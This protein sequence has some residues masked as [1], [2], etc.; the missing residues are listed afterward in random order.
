MGSGARDRARIVER[1]RARLG[2]LDV[3]GSDRARRRAESR[4]LLFASG[5][6]LLTAWLGRDSGG[7]AG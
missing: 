1:R 7:P 4:I 6:A 2:D 5:L 3:A